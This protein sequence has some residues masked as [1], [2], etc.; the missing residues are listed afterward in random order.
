MAGT[1]T[2]RVALFSIHPRYATAILDGTKT[3]EFRRQ[4]LPADVTH[5]AIYAT[6]P[7]QR[8]VGMF[9][10][11]GIDKVTP[12]RAWK[13]YGHV[14][15]IDQTPFERYYTGAENAFVIRVQNPNTFDLPVALSD[16]DTSIRP[17]QSYMYLSRPLQ[18]RLTALSGS[19]SETVLSR[20]HLVVRT[21]T[22]KV[23]TATGR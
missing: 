20:L 16:L 1:A 12:A 23:L 21:A 19:S 4:G 18:E 13:K 22:A 2:G 11:E 17:P 15:G 8:V 14:G 5:I 3:V 9:E 7:V 6:S 10:I